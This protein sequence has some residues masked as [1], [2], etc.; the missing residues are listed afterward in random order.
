MQGDRPG[1]KRTPLGRFLLYNQAFG[2]RLGSTAQDL[3]TLALF[4]N[5]WTRRIMSGK[6]GKRERTLRSMGMLMKLQ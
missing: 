1:G 2:G 3:P 4:A 6:L 5:K